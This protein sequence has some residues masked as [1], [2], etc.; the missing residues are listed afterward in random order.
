M[1]T[2]N[3]RE[4]AYESKFAHD[5]EMQFKAVARGNRLL[6]QWAAGLLGKS[7]EAADAYALSVVKSDFEEPGHEDVYR[8]LF[9]DLAHR[10][11]EA[12]IRTKM[13][14]CLAEAKV[15]LMSERG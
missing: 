13:A 7:G 3:E 2:F 4:R 5:L 11:D 12:T 8:K 9:G 1:T 10:V 14:E 15:Q 6:G